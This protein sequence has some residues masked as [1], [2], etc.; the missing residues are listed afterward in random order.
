MKYIA[1]LVIVALTAIFA[2]QAYW[3]VGMYGTM[4]TKMKTD[5]NE[6]IRI[7]DYAEMMHRVEVLR[8][9][10]DINH[11]NVELSAGYDS[12]TGSRKIASKTITKSS[13][14]K[15]N[16]R[17]LNMSLSRNGSTTVKYDTDTKNV[18]DSE[19]NASEAL[20]QSKEGFST[21]LKDQKNMQALASYMQRGLHDG[22]SVVA[23]PDLKYF[24]KT[25]TKSLKRLGI[26]SPHQL[27][28]LNYW[29]SKDT[30]KV[31]TDTLACIG[32]TITHAVCKCSLLSC[33]TN[34]QKIQK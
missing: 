4:R 1:M 16:K 12:N 11:G 10:K 6:A 23:D 2:Y 15:T 25:L 20:L 5:I 19:A 26:K 14:G 18:K 8:K 33:V 13:T 34:Y 22:L 7:S 24:D 28:Y 17:E 31:Y 3:L 9:R 32:K 21:I 27:Y 30:T 29:T